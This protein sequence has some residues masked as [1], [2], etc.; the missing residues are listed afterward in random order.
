MS[1]SEIRPVLILGAGING[2]AVARELVLNNIPVCIVDSNDIAFGSTAKSSR[3]IHGGLRYLEYGDIGL[4]RESLEERDRLL[5][6]APHFVRPL[7]LF[8]PLGT[9]LG[10]LFSAILKFCGL[11]RFR[12]GH[13]LASKLDS[14]AGRG[15][16]LVRLGLWFYDFLPTDRSL[17]KHSALPAAAAGVP[18]VNSQLYRWLCTYWDTQMIYPERFVLAMLEDVRQIARERGLQVDIFTYHQAVREGDRLVIKSV[19]AGVHP[20]GQDQVAKYID[21]CVI[22]NATG[23][24]GDDTLT[25]LEVP[26][27]RL[28]AGT[29]GSHIFSTH[30]RLRREIGSDGIYAE[31]LD[32]RMVFILPCF[33][34]V[35]IGTTDIRSQNAPQNAVASSQ[36]IDYLIEMVNQVL[37]DVKLK[38][39]DI[40]WH[41]SGVRPLPYLKHEATTSIPRGHW[42]DVNTKGAR[43]VLTLIGGKLTTCRSLAEQVTN[44]V[45]K[46]LG[47][48]RVGS[49]RERV[50]PGGAC[51]ADS[52]EETWRQLS[53]RFAVRESQVRAVWELCGTRAEQVFEDIFAALEKR[54]DFGNVDPNKPP[55]AASRENLVGTDIPLAYVNWLIENEW[56][57]TLD[58]LVERRLMLV[59]NTDLSIPC[60]QALA[61]C[62]NAA[63]ILPRE[64]AEEEV[65]RTIER[66]RCHYGRE[67]RTCDP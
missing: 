3:L 1:S 55:E 43:P 46:R 25:Q 54:S 18:R 8:V 17:P 50:I 49:S 60:L 58:D 31:A 11:S 14:S 45:L 24:W 21:P 61:D 6:L 20:T 57:T 7:R 35:L 4:V 52:Q 44:L 28:F 13:L 29:K 63:G 62:L 15:V 51:D 33:K 56:V 42:I 37:P 22:V 30:D 27:R 5:R 67:L 53:E 16:W 19:P 34:G 36:E 12:L 10:G 65:A 40:Q 23:A 59:H 2:A 32:G 47:L 39:D 38:R 41:Y 48:T 9:R 66:L 26:S 64:R